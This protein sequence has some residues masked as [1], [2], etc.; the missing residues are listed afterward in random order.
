MSSDLT[1]RVIDSMSLDE[2]R[3]DVS[4]AMRDILNLS[5]CPLPVVARLESGEL[6]P[7]PQSMPQPSD[8]LYIGLPNSEEAIDLITQVIDSQP[9]YVVPEE[10]GVYA[11]ASIGATRRPLEYALAAAVIVTL[12]RR[13][14]QVI[15]D[16]ALLWCSNLES[17]PEDFVRL[18][19][20]KNP[21]G[22]LVSSAAAFYSHLPVGQRKKAV[23]GGARQEDEKS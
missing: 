3:S 9:P 16:N 22:D 8:V 23:L 12:A 18:I 6:V 7:P 21:Q 1:T 10:A 13:S 2:F 5:S 19:S 20:L 11:T 4:N 17:D 15:T 14:S